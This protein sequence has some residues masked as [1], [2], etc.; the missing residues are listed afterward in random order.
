MKSCAIL[1][2]SPVGWAFEELAQKLSYVLWVDVSEEPADYNYVLGW[3]ENDIDSCGKMFIPFEG[4]KLAS[5]KR[6]LARIFADSDV[7]TPKT[8]ICEDREELREAILLHRRF[9]N[10]S[11]C[12]WC[13]KWPLSCGATGHRIITSSSDIPKNWPKP[14]LLQKFIRQLDPAVYRLYC[15]NGELFGWNARKFPDG[16]KKSPWVAHAR[17]ARYVE[18]G[19]AP[20]LALMEAKKA[21]AA[22][23]LLGS[24]GCVDLMTDSDGSWVVLE[25]GTDGVFNYV[26]RELG[27][28]DWEWEI[29]R[30]VAESFWSSFDKKP[31]GE[32]AWRP[33]DKQG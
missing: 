18:A 1:N 33:R 2:K 23:N 21:L 28:L 13:L 20:I 10:D 9:E 3:E 16:V 30:R 32:G 19:N 5:D 8:L 15:A 17:G 29:K 11:N 7:R 31:W 12:E 22:T 26:D 25:V 24:F 14:F 6:L 4:I 27:N